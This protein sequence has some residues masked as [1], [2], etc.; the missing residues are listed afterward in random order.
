MLY[1]I[2]TSVLQRPVKILNFS[3][4]KKFCGPNM[5]WLNRDFHKWRHGLRGGGG[6]KM[7]KIE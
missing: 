6:S 3:A 7:S 4:K 5:K 1:N 2:E